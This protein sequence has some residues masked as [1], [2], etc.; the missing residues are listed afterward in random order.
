M[1]DLNKVWNKELE[2]LREV[3]AVC[4]KNNIKYFADSG[5]LLGTV[6]HKGFIPWDDDI[7]LVMFRKE[8]NRF[9]RIAKKE[10][11]AKLFC[12]SGYNDRGF[13]G[14][15]LH[16]RMNGTTA[17]QYQNF[18]YAN[19]HQ[20][21]FIDIFPLDGVIENK[22]FFTLQSLCK[23]ILNTIMWYKNTHRMK[24][25]KHHIILFFPSLLPQVLLFGLFEFVCSWKK[26]DKSEYV[27]V[28]SY[29]GTSGTGQRKRSLYDQ[30]MSVPFED[31]HIPVPAGYDEILEIMYGKEYMTPKKIPADHGEMFFDTKCSYIDYISGKREITRNVEID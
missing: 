28:I 19:Y 21:I 26:T 27:D 11:S 6:R 9:R 1:Q 7:D 20:G 16:I 13:Y 12:Q 18:P 15:M 31:T 5:T 23:K 30:I 22:F 25:I 29:F 2:I 24:R 10:M 8:F 17:I 14:G 4:R 3:D